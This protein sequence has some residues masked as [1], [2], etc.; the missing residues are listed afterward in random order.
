[1]RYAV[2]IY[3]KPGAYDRFSDDER[4]ALS[5]EYLELARDARVVGGA[6]LQGLETA[7]TVRVQD[8]QSLITDGPFADTKEVF[9][10]FYLIEAD[11]LDQATELAARLPAARLGGAVEIRP[12]IDN[13]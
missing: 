11:D 7:T 13:G 12:V 1:M 8:G 3:E 4:R 2:L 5:A 10:G 9:G 6:Q